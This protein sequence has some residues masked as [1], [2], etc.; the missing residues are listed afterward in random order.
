MRGKSILGI[1][2]YSNE[3]DALTVFV[4]SKK[5]LPKFQVLDKFVSKTPGGSK[6]WRSNTQMTVEQ[7][8]ALHE[9]SPKSMKQAVISLRR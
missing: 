9:K 1:P 3:S 7:I 2:R 8:F 5:P 6:L 4:P